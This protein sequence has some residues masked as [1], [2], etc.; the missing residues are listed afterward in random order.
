MRLKAGGKR[1]RLPVAHSCSFPI[2]MRDEVSKVGQYRKYFS[3]SI[4]RKCAR[5][6][7]NLMSARS[8]LS[9]LFVRAA[10]GLLCENSL[11][12]GGIGIKDCEDRRIFF[13]LS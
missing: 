9:T 1:Q 6:I 5:L 13:D 2:V 3:M 11:K 4:L 12:L 8:L 10:K 7:S